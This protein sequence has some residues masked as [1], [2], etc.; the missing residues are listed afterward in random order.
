MKRKICLGCNWE[1]NNPFAEYCSV[2]GAYLTE[3]GTDGVQEPDSPC[4]RYGCQVCKDKDTTVMEWDGGIMTME[5][6][7][8]IVEFR[9]ESSE[10]DDC[11]NPEAEV[12]A[13]FIKRCWRGHETE[14][15]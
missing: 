2:C 14:T 5:E 10:E 3:E 15:G 7:W 8:R 12:A 4:D 13:A 1:E 6:A 9:C 11:W